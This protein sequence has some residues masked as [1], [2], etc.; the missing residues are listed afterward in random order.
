MQAT[1]ARRFGVLIDKTWQESFDLKSPLTQEQINYAAF[2]VRMP[3][4]IREHQIRE[5]TRD[6]L[7]STIQIE[8]DALPAYCDMSLNGLRIDCDK[9]KARIDAVLKQRKEDLGTLDET[10]VPVV[11]RKT[12][13]IDLTELERREKIWREGF[14]LTTPEEMQKAEEIRSARDSTKKAEIRAELKI[15]KNARLAKK[16]EARRAYS[17]LNKQ[18]TELKKALPKMEGEAALNY[19]SD[20]QLLSA[21]KQIKGLKTLKSCADEHLLK[22]NDRPFIQVLRRY[23]KGRK[24]TGTYGLA[25]IQ[26]WITQASAK[27]GWMHPWDKRI[28]ATWNQLEAE[29]GRS[30]SQKPSVMNLPV[31][32]DAEVRDCF[33]A[34]EP[35]QEEP[36]GYV[37]VTADMSGA[38]LRIIA[39]LAQAKTWLTA[40]AKKQDVHA[41][42]TEVLKPLD[43]KQAAL[44]DCT[45]YA[46]HNEE[47]VKLNDKVTIGECRREKCNCPLH[48]DLRG[49]TKEINFQLTYG[50]GPSALADALGITEYAAKELMNLHEQ[51]FPDVWSYLE[52]SGEAA[53][54]LKEARDLYGRRRKFTEPTWERAKEWFKDEYPESLE[55][56]EESKE[57]NIINFK[58]AYLL[59]PN[60]EEEHKLTHREPNENEIRRAM[61][62]MYGRISRQGKNHPAQGTN[63]SMA[64]RAMSCGVDKDGKGYLW[65]LLPQFK[66]RQLSFVH[67]EFIV[68]CPTRFGQEVLECIKDAV[69]RAGT[70]VL[71]SVVMEADGVVDTKW[72]K[73]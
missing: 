64:K 19:G 69:R 66:A 70:E 4:S 14:E 35:D 18:Y 58:A 24:T 67:D 8:N 9:W 63:V 54:R 50:G 38:E 55:L 27:E 51:K 30:S 72:N 5:A 23:R 20:E 40:F 13:Q 37:I 61:R 36:E 33:I 39:E 1:V 31:R 43:W 46:L 6:G 12:E 10:F 60:K 22:F 53:Q 49:D 7:L 11:G 56:P 62:S 52:R 3:L 29:T 68:E 65:H 26:Q 42:S 41:V 48:K 45:Y 25:W 34:S 16:A 47:S 21:L 57:K 15:L 73:G 32:E 2:D 28:H 71:K 59:D 17:E 44:P